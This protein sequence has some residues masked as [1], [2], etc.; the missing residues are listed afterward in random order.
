MRSYMSVAP[1][2]GSEVRPYKETMRRISEINERER[3]RP[4]DMDIR[5]Q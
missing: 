1:K 5:E 2:M 3:G 4:E